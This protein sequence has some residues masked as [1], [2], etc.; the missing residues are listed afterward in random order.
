MQT[1]IT[2][3]YMSKKGIKEL[4]KE[5][6]HLQRD[7]RKTIHEL[8]DIDK[9][10]D[11]DARLTRI[12]KLANFEAIEQ[13]LAEKQSLLATAKPFPKAN[14]QTVD[15]GSTVE[16]Q[17]EDGQYLTYMLV[18][19]A[20]ANPSDRRISIKSPLGQSLIGKKITD[21]INW[22]RGHMVRRF[23]LVRIS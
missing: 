6:R 12:E 19:T 13:E 17:T 14:K 23:R 21:T 2:T 18:D 4:K 5:I 7:L 11:H 16:L 10:T 22:S 3:T 1:T 20:E 9:T 8:H 15:L